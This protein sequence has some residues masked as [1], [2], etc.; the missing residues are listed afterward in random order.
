MLQHLHLG[1]TQDPG[2]PFGWMVWFITLFL[3]T[4]KFAQGQGLLTPK[5]GTNQRNLKN[6]ANVAD[7]ICLAL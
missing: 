6:W 3:Q 1:G 4:T 5:K 2:P 7:K